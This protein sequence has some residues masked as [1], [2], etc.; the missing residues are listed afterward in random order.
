MGSAS[1]LWG[2]LLVSFQVV[3]R[4]VEGSCLGLMQCVSLQNL[5]RL[6]CLSA[7]PLNPHA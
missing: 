1:S 4:V 2:L 7:P 5:T 6:R 3:L